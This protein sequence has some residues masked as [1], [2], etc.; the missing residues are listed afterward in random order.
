MNTTG[1]VMNKANMVFWKVKVS[2][3]FTFKLNTK[4]GGGVA[5]FVC[6]NH[7]TSSFLFSFRFKVQE[8][9]N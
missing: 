8:Y 7:N 9:K 3:K 5:S 2:T 1:H 6:F 4:V